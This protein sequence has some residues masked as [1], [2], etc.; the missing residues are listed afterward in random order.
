MIFCCWRL[1]KARTDATHETEA[2][3]KNDLWLLMMRAHALLSLPAAVYPKAGIVAGMFVVVGAGG[4][5]ES[6][7]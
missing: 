5:G 3:I 1:R 4:G 6:G 2:S 7:H